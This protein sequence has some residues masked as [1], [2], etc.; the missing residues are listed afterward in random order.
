MQL[1]P[2]AGP[3]TAAKVLALVAE[4]A[5]AAYLEVST[6]RKCPEGVWALF[7]ETPGEGAEKQANEARRE[8]LAAKVKEATFVTL[9]PLGGAVELGKYDAKKKVLP[10]KIDGA[11][12][13]DLTGQVELRHGQVIT[14]EG[15][16]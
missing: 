15:S 2:G 12:T 7:P 11:M 8:A 13:Y 1:L 6:G 10:V 4:R 9:L 16:A 5:D 3:A 14:L